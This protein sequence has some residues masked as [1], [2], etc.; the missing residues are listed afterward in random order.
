M[1]RSA[2]LTGD[3]K[4]YAVL[5]LAGMGV[6]ASTLVSPALPGMAAA[7][8]LTEARVGL[9]MTSFF[10]T[11]VVAI[12]IVGS[13]ADVVG[14]RAV[15]LTSLVVFG[16]AGVLIGFVDAFGAI[17]LLR[18]IQ[19]CAFPGL[20]PM[21]ITLIGDLYEGRVA[22]TAQGFLTSVTGLVGVVSP[23]LS[24]ALVDVSWRLPFGI[25]AL[26]FV[27]FGVCYR[28]LPEPQAAPATDGGL[29][30]SILP[31]PS[32]FLEMGREVRDA[33]SVEARVVIVGV[34]VLFL[35][36]YA[37]FTFMPLYAVTV[38]GASELLGGVTVAVLGLGRLVVAPSAGRLAAR[39]GRPPLL[40]GSLV[41]FGVGTAAL[42]LTLEPWLVVAILGIASVGDGLFDPI[43]NDVVTAT[44]APD[45]RGRVVSVLEVGK[46][47]AISL[48]PIAFGLLLS[49]SSYSVLFATGGA[50]AVLTAGLVGAVLTDR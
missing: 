15:F 5:G 14:R 13:L 8:E 17:L 42:L 25:Y 46:T 45:V 1:S 9:V 31:S 12:P 7:F 18:A 21:S 11:A 35:V 47:G 3:P 10:L 33:L 34:V 49:A 23:L 2:D 44:A 50:L 27:A 30:R 26:S 38:L 20:L 36:R 43:A 4:L 24:G 28:W 16:L 48:S 37:L 40:V 32:R 29:S 39:F 41:L 22:T 19:G 6:F